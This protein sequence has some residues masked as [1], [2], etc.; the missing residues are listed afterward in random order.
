MSTI[1]EKSK[2]S[3]H[4]EVIKYKISAGAFSINIYINVYVIHSWKQINDS[5]I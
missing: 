4:K 1:L 3:S 2:I 5:K